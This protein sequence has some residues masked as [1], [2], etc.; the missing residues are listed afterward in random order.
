M[1]DNLLVRKK[2]K[3]GEIY[4]SGAVF[5]ARLRIAKNSVRRGALERPHDAY[6]VRCR[7]HAYCEE[8]SERV[9]VFQLKKFAHLQ[10]GLG[11]GGG[12]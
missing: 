2:L 7:V 1:P 9:R 5:F 11:P 12:C 10:I 6:P 3:V 8:C 4:G